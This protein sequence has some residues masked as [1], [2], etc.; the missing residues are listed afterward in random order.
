MSS[1]IVVS[2]GIDL[3][4]SMMEGYGMTTMVA[5][6]RLHP[7]MPRGVS[8]STPQTFAVLQADAFNIALLACSMRYA[9]LVHKIYLPQA[10][11]TVLQAY[12]YELRGDKMSITYPAILGIKIHGC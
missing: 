4:S 7:S 1:I 2:Q 9:S 6:C 3:A 12:G 10:L 11:M 5:A 8:C